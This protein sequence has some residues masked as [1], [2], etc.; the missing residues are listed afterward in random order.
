MD[1]HVI[2][3]FT[4]SCSAKALWDYV[5]GFYGSQSNAARS[6]DWSRRFLLLNKEKNY[7]V[8]ISILLKNNQLNWI[9]CPQT[10]DEKVLQKVEEDNILLLLFKS[11]GLV[12]GF[13]SS[14]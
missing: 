11:K 14:F 2:E 3:I 7:S 8:N 9:Y 5:T 12:L 13:V 6:L 10:I 4:F 1:L